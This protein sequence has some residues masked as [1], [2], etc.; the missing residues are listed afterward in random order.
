MGDVPLFTVISTA[1]NQTQTGTEIVRGIASNTMIALQL[2][3]A[4]TSYLNFRDDNITDDILSSEFINLFSIR[5]PPSLNNPQVT[6]SI[7]YMEEFE[8]SSTFDDSYD[9]TDMA[10]CGRGALRNSSQYLIYGNSLI[11]D[12]MCFAYKIAAGG[13]TIMDFLIESDGNTP[14]LEN[15]PLNLRTDSRWHYQCINLRD[16][17]EQYSLTYL[18]VT[19][20]VIVE[21]SLS[22]FFPLS[23]MIDTVTLRNDVPIGYEDDITINSTDQSS[24]GPCTFPF[25]YNGKSHSACILDNNNQPICGLNSNKSFFCQNSSIEGI[26]R[27]YPKYQLLQ[28]LFQVNHSPATHTID[29]SFRYTA[30]MSPSLAKVIPPS[31]S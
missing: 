14:V 6:P 9:V 1:F 17:L 3:G 26:R 10:F 31:V 16:T 21:V 19:T 7:I 27:L 11:A 25:S 20:I 30:C 15:I 23:I 12:Y 22:S 18:T 5:C 2:D 4:T 8:L 28:N 24:T 13:S 29:I